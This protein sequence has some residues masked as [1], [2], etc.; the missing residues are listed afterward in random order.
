M[1]LGNKIA[2]RK[3]LIDKEFSGFSANPALGTSLFLLRNVCV[4]AKKH[5]RPANGPKE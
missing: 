2:F 3:S 4:L 1:G 5:I